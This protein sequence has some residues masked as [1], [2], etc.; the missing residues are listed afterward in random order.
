MANKKGQE[1]GEYLTLKEFARVVGIP[2]EIAQ[3]S[4]V[5]GAAPLNLHV[6]RVG[7]EDVVSHKDAAA[8]L[9]TSYAGHAYQERYNRKFGKANECRAKASVEAA[10]QQKEEKLAKLQSFRELIVGALESSP[11]QKHLQ[12][13]IESLDKQIAALRGGAVGAA[14]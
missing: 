13:T 6:Q 1:I 2:V 12:L 14:S 11:E 9:S 8:F 7:G 10:H 3:D 4:W 5:K